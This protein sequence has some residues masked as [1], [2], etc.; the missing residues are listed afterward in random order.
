VIIATNY[1]SAAVSQPFTITN[2]P[3]FSTLTPWITSATFTLEQQAGVSVA[4]NSFT[5][6][7]PAQSITT[8]V[9]TP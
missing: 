3:A 4:A 7:L 5:Y 6:T 8:F 2:A 9:G 1:S